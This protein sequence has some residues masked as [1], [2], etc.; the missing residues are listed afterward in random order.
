MRGSS[1]PVATLTDTAPAA[2][3]GNWRPQNLASHALAS[4][5]TGHGGVA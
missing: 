4:Q 2:W 3:P 5:Q 1:R